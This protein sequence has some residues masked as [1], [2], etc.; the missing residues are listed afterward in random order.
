MASGYKA[1]RQIGKEINIRSRERKAL[2]E[3]LAN[4]KQSFP[5]H[6]RRAQFISEPGHYTDVFG[7]YPKEITDHLD[8]VA[9]YESPLGGTNEFRLVKPSIEKAKYYAGIVNEGLLRK[10][11]EDKMPV[12]MEVINDY[13]KLKKEFEMKSDQSNNN[14]SAI[15]EFAEFISQYKRIDGFMEEDPNPKSETPEGLA[16]QNFRKLGKK[17]L[18]ALAEC[19]G[20]KD[21]KVDFN[22]AGPAV[23]GTLTLMA[24]FTSDKGIYISINRDGFGASNLYRSIKNMKDYTGNTNNYFPDSDLMHPE[25]IKKKVYTLLKLDQPMPKMSLSEI[26]KLLPNVG[27][28]KMK[29]EGLTNI[30]EDGFVGQNDITDAEYAWQMTQLDYQQVRAIE[31][32]GSPLVLDAKDRKAHEK[33]VEWALKN[34]KDVPAE[35]LESYPWLSETQK[36]DPELNEQQST[37]SAK[38]ENPWHCAVPLQAAYEGSDFYEYGFDG[39]DFKTEDNFKQLLHI[40]GMSEKYTLCKDVAGFDNQEAIDML[41]PVYLWKGKNIRMV[42]ANN[43]LLAEGYA[44]FIGIDGRKGLV[45]KA[46]SYIESHTSSVG[47][48][49]LEYIDFNGLM[50]V[51]E[52]EESDP[53]GAHT[54]RLKQHAMRS[55][56]SANDTS[57]NKL[58][59][60]ELLSSDNWFSQ[61]P[62]KILGEQYETTDRFNKAVTKVR[63]TIKNVIEGIDIPSIAEEQKQTTEPNAKVEVHSELLNNPKKKANV[64]RVIEETKKAQAE[65]KLIKLTS[66]KD[67]YEDG[68]PEEYLCF[69]DLMRIYNEGISEEEVKAWI[70]YKRKVHGYNDEKVVLNTKNGWSKYVVPLGEA[71]SHLKEWLNAGIVCC[72]KDIFMPSVLYYAENIY[73]RERQ[74]LSDKEHIIKT[75]GQQQFDRQWEGLQKVKPEK[76]ILTHPDVNSRLFIKPDSTLAKEIEVGELADGTKFSAYAKSKGY[77]EEGSTTLV[78]AFKTWL[79]ALPKDDFKKSTDWNIIQYYLE[80]ATPSRHHDKE[81]KLRLR[82]NAKVEGDQLFIRFMAEALTREDQLKIEQAWN[83]KY[84]AYVE[85]NYFKVPIA[86]TCSSTFKNKPLFIRPAQREGIGFISVHGSG[87]V[88]YDVGL[89]KTMTGILSLAQAM[90]SGQ[91]KRPFIVVPNQTYKNWLAEIQGVVE[92]GKVLLSGLLPQYQVIDLYNLGTDFVDQLRDDKGKLRKVPEYSITVMTYEGFNRLGFNDD[93]WKDIGDQLFDILNQGT[94]E[95]RD[96]IQLGEKINELIGKG[97]KGGLVNIEDLGLDYMV[98]DEAHAMKKSFTQ[99]KGEM[100]GEGEK[101]TRARGTYQIRSG[102]PS[103]TALRGFMISQYIL[104]NN[105]MRNVLLLTATPFTNSPLEIY[106]ILAL[107]GYQQMEKWGIKNIKEFFDTFIKTSMELVIN[108]KLKPERKEIVL[109]FNNLVALQQLIFKFITYKTGEDAKIQRPRKIVLPMFNKMEG[110]KLVPL[111]AEQQISTNLPMTARQ[112]EYMNDVELYVRGKTSL[113][114]FCVNTKGMEDAEDDD[115]LDTGE[116]L[117]EKKLSEDEEEGTRILRGMSF[118]RQLALSPY[119]YACNPDKHPTAEQYIETS[120]KLNYIMQCI[121]SVKRFHEER[122]EEVSGQVIYMNA[123]VHFFP[124]IKEYLVTK[125]GFRDEEVG[126]IRSGMSAAKKEGIKERFLAG[127]V[128]VI[129]GS[130]TIKEGINLQNRATVLYNAWLDWNP[131]DVK[132]LEGRIWR[133][134]N[135]YANVRIVNP[136]MEDSIDTFIFQK[137][138]EKTSRINEIWYRSGKTNALSLE[139]FNPSELKMGLVTDPY[140]LAELILLS[141]RERLQDDITSLNNQETVL[142]EIAEQREIFN[143]NIDYIQTIVNRYR[144][145]KSGD[146]ARSTETIFKLF[147]EYLDDEETSYSYKDQTVFDQ[148]RKAHASI[149]RGIEQVLQPRGLDIGFDLKKITAMMDKE[150]EHKRKYMEEKTGEKAVEAKGKEIIAERI[151]KGYK[152]KTVAERVSEFTALNPKLLTE[153]MVYD[154]SEEAKTKQVQQNQKGKVLEDTADRLTKIIQ[155]RDSFKRMKS[156]LEQIRE[157]RKAA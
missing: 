126:I 53:S 96:Q 145:Q 68:C 83:S 21:Y 17:A 116:V 74:L 123:G 62:E 94:E 47:N 19:L 131:T 5:W 29:T 98:V 138:E 58:N 7:S 6:K 88:A 112:K 73:E 92:K 142:K 121:R 66:G 67:K 149:K 76:L 9:V 119:L 129:I 156:R 82:Q 39:T 110:E 70:W 35:V 122:H 81:E 18:K 80:N 86:F 28:Y 137:L 100:K 85:I 148:V 31:K 23:S 40:T 2:L 38:K 34:G 84:N 37:D 90:E 132:Q 105:N 56:T 104:R 134:G 125:V 115:E 4:E 72:Y 16:K 69:D 60:L 71:S 139:E 51:P 61:H 1:F 130:A 8:I 108:A 93:T 111:P 57:D 3:K 14:I 102:N 49:G 136:L 77:Y 135:M 151:K 103:M 91:C 107:I 44:S 141:D 154:N 78:E 13:P 59:S 118:A 27:V 12:L 79:R 75:H 65:K 36:N 144:P 113:T 42:T 50:C 55:N 46:Y 54:E 33:F 101:A 43:P 99:V 157:L 30:G 155:L 10:A 64:E 25:E 97:I 150:I 52:G 127:G 11:L 124:L 140:A 146:K 24:M 63:G 114:N 41:P 89:G 45:Q 87:C 32:T 147:R 128:K 22:P 109:G 133:F 152:P 26:N 15:R 48:K 120:P 106:S 143:K 20:L 153:L 95:R 117:D